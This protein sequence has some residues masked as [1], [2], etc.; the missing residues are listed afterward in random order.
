MTRIAVVTGGTRGIGE[1]I[2]LKLKEKGRHVIANYGGNDEAAR[3]F[4]A[5]TGIYVRKWDVGDHQACLD[6]C[7]EIEEQF[8]PIDILVN[9]AGIT[10]DATIMKMTFEQWDEVIR[11]DLPCCFNL[12]TACFPN[13]RTRSLGRHVHV[14]FLIQL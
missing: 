6:A 5:R 13:M 3:A 11:I 2:S 9:N 4:S 7:A 1:A 12:A 14:P 10:R 8:G